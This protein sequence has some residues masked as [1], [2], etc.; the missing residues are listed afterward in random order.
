MRYP[1]GHPMKI[2]YGWRI[3]VAGSALQFLQ[4][5]LLNQAFGAYVAALVSERGWSKTALAGAASLKSTEAALLGPALGWLIDRF[6]SQGIIRAGV[7]LFG[8]GFMLLSQID[9]LTGFYAAFVVLALGASMCSNITVSVAI[10]HWFERLRARALSSLQFGHA[11]GGM[12]VVLVAWSIEGLGWR[13][14]A[15]A[16][17]VLIIVVGWPMARIIRSRPEDHGEVVDG[18]APAT[19]V[20]GRA[21]ASSGRAFT[22]R[23]AVRTSAF[24]LISLGHGFALFAVTAVNVHAITHVKEGLGYSIAQGALVITLVTVGQFIGVLLGW[25]L[26]EKFEKRLVAAACMLMHMVGLLM[27]TYATGP[28]VLAAS[29]LI[30][31]TAWGLRGPFMQAIR[32]DYFGRRSIGMIIGLS[33]MI[34]VIGQIGGPLIAGAF[35]DVYGN[36]RAGFTLLALLSGLGSLFF[37]LAKPPK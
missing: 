17:G 22:A 34:T 8:I 26:G 36:Y 21:A 25:V 12:F 16:S 5:M 37:V 35:A 20:A 9:S 14:T 7:V 2:F 24:W 10:I 23:E 18:A 27:L 19:V 31:G 13:V 3:V 28:I 30:H 4:S 1:L 11:L 29:A 15:F 6:G 32:A 33:S